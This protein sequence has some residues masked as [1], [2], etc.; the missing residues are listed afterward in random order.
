MSIPPP[1]EALERIKDI[2]Y[3]LILPVTTVV[4]VNF[5]GWA[6]VTR[7]V[8][9]GIFHEDY[10]MVARAKGVPERRVIFKHVLRSAAP[11]IVTMTLFALIGSLG[12]ALITEAVFNWPGMGRLYWV[13]IQQ[14]DVPVLLGTTT[15]STILYLLVTVVVDLIYGL[16]DPRVK[17]GAA[18]KTGG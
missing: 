12:G 13:A 17:V 18:V 7:N 14:Q 8:V 3:H 5:G 2:L 10:V 9:L 4:F 15:V 6:Y 16:L 1:E 11:P